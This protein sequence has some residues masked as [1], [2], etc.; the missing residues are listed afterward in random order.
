M[1]SPVPESVAVSTTGKNNKTTSRKAKNKIDTNRK[2]CINNSIFD[3]ARPLAIKDDK[4]YVGND[5]FAEYCKR[6][7]THYKVK[8]QEVRVSK[9]QRGSEAGM[10]LRLATVEDL[11]IDDEA[12]NI[13]TT[14]VKQLSRYHF[15][16]CLNCADDCNLAIYVWK[17]KRNEANF[18]KGTPVLAATN[19]RKAG[20]G[21]GKAS[22]ASVEYIVLKARVLNAKY[23]HKARSGFM[24]VEQLTKEFKRKRY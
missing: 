22:V 10:G 7:I 6:F 8:F 15:E 20:T 1:Q 5:D 21:G 16:D 3:W 24:I 17:Q 11:V 12:Y 13:R 2:A 14:N 18:F 23:H 4:S 9:K 19:P